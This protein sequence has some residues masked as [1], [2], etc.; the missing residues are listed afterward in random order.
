MVESP[1]KRLSVEN[2]VKVREEVRGVPPTAVF[3]VIAATGEVSGKS[4]YE[5][6][7]ESLPSSKQTTFMFLQLT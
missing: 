3:G 1:E 4:M 5:E 2:S 7:V 6:W